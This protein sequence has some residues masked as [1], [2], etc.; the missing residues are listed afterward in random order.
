[1][2]KS[3]RDLKQEAVREPYEFVLESP[4]ADHPGFVTFKD[5]NALET[6]S[7][8]D[9]DLMRP[10]EVFELL[11]SKEDHEIWWNEFRSAPVRETRGLLEDIQRH[12]GAD[13]GKPRR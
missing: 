9:L 2:R 13:P 4:P 6:E 11:L 8:F 5:P 1:M 12:Y 10:S 3:R 7:A